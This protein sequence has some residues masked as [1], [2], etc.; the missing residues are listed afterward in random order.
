MFAQ[1]S[2]GAY[3]TPVTSTLRKATDM[4]VDA[5]ERNIAVVGEA[6][7]H[8]PEAVTKALLQI[9]WPA[10]RAGCEIVANRSLGLTVVGECF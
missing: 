9:D 10:I 3:V 1:R 8:L 6:A 4:A 2:T 7:N 5:I